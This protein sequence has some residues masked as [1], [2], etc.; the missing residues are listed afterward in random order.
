MKL[1]RPELPLYETTLPFSRKVVSY[2]PYTSKEEKILMMAATS[3]VEDDQIHAAEQIIKLCTG[4]EAKKLAPVDVEWIFLKLRAVS[5]SNTVDVLIE[6]NCDDEECPKSDK[7]AVILDKIEIKNQ[8]AIAEKFKSNTD[9][10]IVP[11]GARSGLVINPIDNTAGLEN[12]KYVWSCLHSIVKDEEVIYKEEITEEEFLDWFD[13]F[14]RIDK[15][16]VE[17]FF[18]NAPYTYYKLDHKCRKCGKK[19]TVE[20]ESLIDFLD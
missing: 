5:V 7:A 9:G 3:Q 16:K 13:S 18:N 12:E 4:L 11:I 1:E 17:E 19:Y 10:W 2:R 20:M 6:M 8:D 15:N 14:P